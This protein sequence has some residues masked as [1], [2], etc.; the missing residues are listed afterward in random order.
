MK[1]VGMLEDMGDELNKHLEDDKA[2]H[3]MM[4][5]WRNTIELTIAW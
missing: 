2:V 3:E 4:D 1:V 5:C